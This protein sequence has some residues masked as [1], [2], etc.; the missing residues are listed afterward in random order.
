M[1]IGCYD[2][3]VQ[4]ILGNEMIFY[5]LFYCRS[6]AHVKKRKQNCRNFL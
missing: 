4:V 5:N 1:A 2:A 3:G 6:P